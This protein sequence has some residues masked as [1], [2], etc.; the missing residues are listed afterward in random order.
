MVLDVIAGPDANDSTCLPSGYPGGFA[1]ALLG[2]RWDGKLD[3]C[4]EGVT[5]GIPKDF[6]VKELG[7][8]DTSISHLPSSIGYIGVSRGARLGYPT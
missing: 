6:N 4:L 5:V 2:G 7:E 1:L 8:R 3:G